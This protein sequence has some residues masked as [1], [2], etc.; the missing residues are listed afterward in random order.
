MGTDKE[1]NPI[2]V[3]YRPTY[4]VDCSPSE[5]ENDGYE[6]EVDAQVDNAM[7]SV[8]A[9]DGVRRSHREKKNE[10]RRANL[11]NDLLVSH[12]LEKFGLEDVS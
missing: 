4:M 3:K 11:K 1:G 6:Y 9:P 2:E 12:T 10:L 7:A 8:D 5:S